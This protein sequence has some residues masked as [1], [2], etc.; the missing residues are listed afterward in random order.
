[1]KHTVRR[2][3]AVRDLLGARRYLE[4]GVSK[5]ATFHAVDFA[6][7][8]AVDPRFRFDPDAHAAPN[9]VYHQVTS[10]TFFAR[11]AGP[12]ER[13][14]LIFVDGLHT[15]EQTLRDLISA[16]AVLAPGGALLIDDV[17]PN[18]VYSALR[19][20][21]QA[22]QARAAAGGAGK[23]WHGDVYKVVFALH[24]L[25]PMLDYRTFSDRGNPQTLV[26][27][28]PRPDFAPR[29]DDLEAISRLGYF[30]MRQP[31]NLAVLKLAPEAAVLD[32]LAAHAGTGPTGPGGAGGRAGPGEGERPAE[33]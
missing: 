30:D 29:F 18:D 15:F 5:G 6:R 22:V 32:W 33:P 20:Q 19:D 14:D 27:R 21:R 28:R 10:D 31:P 7:Q 24:D 23:S 26:I 4:I 3:R 11:L 8:V 25:F 13:F 17:L 2:L 12:E 9:R 1:M 16:L